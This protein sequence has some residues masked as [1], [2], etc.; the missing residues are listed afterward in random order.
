LATA[1]PRLEAYREL[2][3]NS[4]KSRWPKKNQQIK[5]IWRISPEEWKKITPQQ[6]ARLVDSMPKK[7]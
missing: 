7:V 4:Q 1:E 2:V 3:G 6:C 5:T